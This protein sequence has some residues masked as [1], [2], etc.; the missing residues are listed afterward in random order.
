VEKGGGGKKGQGEMEKLWCGG[1]CKERKGLIAGK[2]WREGRGGGGRRNLRTDSP[3]GE[4]RK[5]GESSLLK[6]VGLC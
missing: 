5:T 6:G 4:E 3:N 2:P 1:H